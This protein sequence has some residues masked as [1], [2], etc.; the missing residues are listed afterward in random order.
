MQFRLAVRLVLLS[1]LGVRY[2]FSVVATDV[3]D[4]REGS[5]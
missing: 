1:L 4:S 5:E 2:E 3:T